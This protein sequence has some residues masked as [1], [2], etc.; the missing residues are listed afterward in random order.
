[1]IPPR[2]IERPLMRLA[3]TS[4]AFVVSFHFFQSA[5]CCLDDLQLTQSLASNS[6]P[7]WQFPT[8]VTDSLFK[9]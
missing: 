1:M 3:S 7:S 9:L 2:R 5:G 6:D 4:M 8:S